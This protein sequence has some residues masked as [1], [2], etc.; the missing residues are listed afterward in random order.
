MKLNDALLLVNQKELIKI[1]YT[2]NE[3]YKK[4]KRFKIKPYLRLE[5]VM[6]L[7]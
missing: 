1:N 6:G 7:I 3:F 5:K 2:K 4:N